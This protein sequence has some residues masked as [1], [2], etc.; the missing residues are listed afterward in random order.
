MRTTSLLA[1]ALT[2]V[3]GACNANKTTSTVGESSST[4]SRGPL[5]MRPPAV[6]APGEMFFVIDPKH[7]DGPLGDEIRKTFAIR[8]P[9]LSPPEPLFTLRNIPPRSMNKT[10]RTMKN[11]IYVATLD[12]T[13]RSGKYLR[14]NFTDESIAEIKSD[15]TQFQYIKNDEFAI[16]QKVVHL[17]GRTEA[18]LIEN[19]ISHREQLRQYFMKV[20]N[21][22]LASVLLDVTETGIETRL[23]NNYAARL[24]VPR[25]YELAYEKEDFIWIRRRDPGADIDRG[26]FIYKEPYTDEAVFTEEGM[27]ALRDRFT[28]RY[29]RDPQ[30]PEVVMER[31]KELYTL[32][33]MNFHN[34]YAVEVRG[35]WRLSDISLGGPYLAYA[36]VNE[37]TSEIYYIEGYVGAPGTDKR[38]YLMELEVILDTFRP[39]KPNTGT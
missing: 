9:G 26:I 35:L 2:L 31:Q 17:F 25:G 16:G 8:V 3:L 10:F 24:K 12:N 27:Q 18:E 11:L 22:R 37:S 23:A 13:S 1:L 29:V 30:K 36:M 21:D 7:W 19:L 14:R 4:Q 15:P 34:K 39:L 6:G 32:Q 28:Q 33:E 38:P 20:E 5:D